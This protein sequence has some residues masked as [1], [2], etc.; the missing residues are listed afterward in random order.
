LSQLEEVLLISSA[1]V[2]PSDKEGTA[3]I[4]AEI[5]KV[6]KEGGL[7]VEDETKEESQKKA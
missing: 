4:E 3:K 1:L 5:E 2:N 7:D 6:R